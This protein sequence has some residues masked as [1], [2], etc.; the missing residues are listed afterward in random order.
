MGEGNFA[1]HV[2]TY[3][4]LS[5][6]PSLRVETATSSG[7]AALFTAYAAIAA[8]LYRSVLVV[9]GEKMTHLPTPRVSEL[10][11]RSIDPYERSYGTTMPALAGLVTCALMSRHGVTE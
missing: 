7:A 4:G 2:A 1:A 9:G 3:L 10:I 8:G 6:T 5:H 11:G